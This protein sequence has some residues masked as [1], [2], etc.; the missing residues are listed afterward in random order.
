MIARLNRPVNRAEPD[1][2]L[3]FSGPLWEHGGGAG[4]GIGAIGTVQEVN[5]SGKGV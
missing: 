4:V 3:A 1:K 2:R 5:L